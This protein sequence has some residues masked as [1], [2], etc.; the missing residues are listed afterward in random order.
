MLRQILDKIS[1]LYLGWRMI[2]LGCAIRVL[3]GGLRAYGVSIFFL[4]VTQELG[5]TRTG[6]SPVFSLASAI[7]CSPASTVTPR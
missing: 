7:C 3:G 1:G 4:P 6:T 5:L 2:A